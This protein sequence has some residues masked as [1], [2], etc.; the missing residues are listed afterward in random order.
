MAF[1]LIGLGLTEKGLSVEAS[2]K[3]KKVD[4]VYLENYT[5]DFPYKKEELEKIIGKKI[6][7]LGREKVENE[8]FLLDAKKKNVALLVYGDVLMATTHMSLILKCKKEKIDY[9]VFHSA[10]IFNAISETGLQMYKFGKTASMPAWNKEKEYKPASFIEIIKDNQKIKAHSLLLTDIALSF[11]KALEQLKEAAKEK[12]LKLNEIIAC[13]RMGTKEQRIFY[14]S[15]ENLEKRKKEIQ[16]P[17]CFIIPSDL[18]FLEKE[19][20]ESFKE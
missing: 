6:V 11:E 2:E 14:D 12:K 5:V 18:H 7:E 19:S 16:L 9:E 3:L 1:Y 15:L 8:G 13:S 10:S 17:F 4:V 20:I